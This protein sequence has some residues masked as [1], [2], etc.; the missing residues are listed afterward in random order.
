MD[1]K[2]HSKIHFVCFDYDFYCIRPTNKGQKTTFFCSIKYLF[3]VLFRSYI[4]SRLLSPTLTFLFS[5]HILDI[6]VSY[7]GDVVNV[8]SMINKQKDF[9]SLWDFKKRFSIIFRH[10]LLPSEIFRKT[11]S[12]DFPFSANIC[13]LSWRQIDCWTL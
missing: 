12:Q 1:L 3:C 2:V 6:N 13:F 7:Q 5:L 10:V 11:I 4:L 9:S 8:T